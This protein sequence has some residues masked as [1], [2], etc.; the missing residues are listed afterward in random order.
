[1]LQMSTKTLG[2]QGSHQG[3]EPAS[4]RAKAPGGSCCTQRTFARISGKA[5]RR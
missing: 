2:I 4:D 3:R 1:V 5:L